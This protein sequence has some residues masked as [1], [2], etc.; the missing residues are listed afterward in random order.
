MI[1]IDILN[2]IKFKVFLR[3]LKFVGSQSIPELK[4]SL[5]I[6]SGISVGNVPALTC[7]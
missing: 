2:I 7:D 6:V 5:L 1:R 3:M 4:G